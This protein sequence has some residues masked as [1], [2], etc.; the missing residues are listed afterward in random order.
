MA[1]TE[2][3]ARSTKTTKVFLCELY[4]DI[5]GRVTIVDNVNYV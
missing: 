2:V 3:R 4:Q 5:Y 1:G